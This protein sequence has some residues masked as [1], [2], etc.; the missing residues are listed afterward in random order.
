M[1]LADVIERARRALY[2]F[3]E[4][5]PKTELLREL[6][7]LERTLDENSNTVMR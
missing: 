2:S 6:D 1:K 7:E 5:L 3:L 4:R